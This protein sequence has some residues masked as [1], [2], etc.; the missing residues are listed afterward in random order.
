MDGHFSHWFVVKIVQF[1]CWKDENN[2]KR[3]SG[4]S[5]K[6]QPDSIFTNVNRWL[7]F[8]KSGHTDFY[9]QSP[10]FSMDEKVATQTVEILLGKLVRKKS[11]DLR[12]I[13]QNFL[14]RTS[15]II[16]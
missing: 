15:G 10:L 13:L 2:Q 12:R 7:D 3:L 16:K 9:L 8:V 11:L 1:V 14:A 6:D 4:I 5:K